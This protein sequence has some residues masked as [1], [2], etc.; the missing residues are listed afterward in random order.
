MTCLVRLCRLFIY[1]YYLQSTFN[2]AWNKNV[3]HSYLCAA[4]V[5][6]SSLQV[7]VSKGWWGPHLHLH[8]VNRLPLY[9]QAWYLYSTGLIW[10]LH[11]DDL[12]SQKK[13]SRAPQPVRIKFEKLRSEDRPTHLSTK[14]MHWYLPYEIIESRHKL[15]HFKNVAQHKQMKGCLEAAQLHLKTKG[16]ETVIW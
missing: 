12:P 16:W 2:F 5:I 14:G 6:T 9:H 10:T 7:T 8:S 4:Q 11:S 1:I 13:Q 3:L 15:E